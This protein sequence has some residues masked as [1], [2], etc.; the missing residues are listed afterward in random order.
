MR[1][2][3]L[4]N[5]HHCSTRLIIRFAARETASFITHA[6]HRCYDGSCAS[7][8]SPSDFGQS[9]W[10]MQFVTPQLPSLA[11]QDHFGFPTLPINVAA[12]ECQLK[13]AQAQRPTR[14]SPPLRAS[15]AY[16]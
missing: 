6:Q 2:R 3:R 10:A 14:A 12:R 15:A 11:V 9:S 5:L 1:V 16:S 8:P 13:A 7:L 4:S